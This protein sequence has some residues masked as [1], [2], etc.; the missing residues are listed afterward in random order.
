M[1]NWKLAAAAALAALAIPGPAS[2]E[3]KLVYEDL[4]LCAA[5]NDVVGEVMG[6]GANGD[7]AKADTFNQQSI[8]LMTIA[9]VGSNKTAEVVYAE[10]KKQSETVLAA[11]ANKDTGAA[12]IEKYYSKCDTMGKAAVSIVDDA[13]K[14]K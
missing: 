3:D 9:A 2:A 12:Y 7:K 14:G 1:R 13:K 5:F 11:M 10:T 4:V 8:A 6:S